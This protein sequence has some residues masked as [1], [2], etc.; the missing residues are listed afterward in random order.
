MVVWRE[1]WM[2][3]CSVARLA[4]VKV[5][6]LGCCA[7][8]MSVLMLAESWAGLRAAAMAELKAAN[9]EMM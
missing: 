1:R 2:V 7:V 8:D 4:A 5:E 9:L 6:K 3:D